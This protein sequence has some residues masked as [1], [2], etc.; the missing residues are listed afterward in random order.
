MVIDGDRITP[1]TDIAEIVINPART[2]L[3]RLADE[4]GLN[5]SNGADMLDA[6]YE[7]MRDFIGLA[8]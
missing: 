1:G 6:Q 7:L 2:T 8:P 4:K 5:W 3:L